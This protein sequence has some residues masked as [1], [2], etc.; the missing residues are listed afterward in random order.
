[1]TNQDRN[2]FAEIMIGLAENFGGQLTA[3]GIDLRFQ[4]MADYSIDDIAIATALLVR[5]RTKAGVPT[6]AEIIEAIPG[7]TKAPSTKDRA[8][9]QAA[10]VM[11]QIRQVGFYGTP[12]FDNP[13]TDW[14]MKTRWN[15][16]SVCTMTESEHKWWQKDFQDA[17]QS[18]ASDP[19][20]AGRLPAPES[21][22]KSAIETLRL[23]AGGIGKGIPQA[24]EKSIGSNRPRRVA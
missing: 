8:S 24:S 19:D 14:L 23:I 6:T 5:T 15:W 10:E 21:D 7:F 17:Y 12:Q 1:M 11:R 3:S 16:R 2:R 22:S 20:I 18:A 9:Q 13:I 4:A